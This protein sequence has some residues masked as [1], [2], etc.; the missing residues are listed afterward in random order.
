MCVLVPY[1]KFEI[2]VE[3]GH[4]VINVRKLNRY[5]ILGLFKTHVVSGLDNF[6]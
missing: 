5:W 2:I 3:K 6:P 4:S 1:F